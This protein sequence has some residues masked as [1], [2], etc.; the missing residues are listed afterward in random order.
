ME[1]PVLIIQFN[2]QKSTTGL[3]ACLQH[4][5]KTLPDPS[6]ATATNRTRSFSQLSSRIKN[7]INQRMRSTW[8]QACPSVS[9]AS[10]FLSSSFPQETKAESLHLTQTSIMDFF[11]PPGDKRSTSQ[12]VPVSRT[13]STS[14]NS[15]SS[16]SSSALSQAPGKHFVACLQEPPVRNDKVVGLP[17]GLQIFSTKGDSRVRAAIVASHGLPLWQVPEFSTPDL[18]VVLW[19]N[20]KTDIYIVS[21]Y[22]DIEHRDVVPQELRRLSRKCLRDKNP[23]LI[24]LDS[25]A[26]SSLWGMENN[27]RGDRIEE[28]LFSSSLK[29]INTGDK[30][31]F[32]NRRSQ[33]VIDIT[34]ASQGLANRLEHWKV[35]DEH[36][37]SDHK[38]IQMYL[39]TKVPP[40]HKVFQWSK[41]DWTAFF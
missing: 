4:V 19:K 3:T 24:C 11:S 26:H 16:Q 40:K 41:C 29:V 32:F 17:S 9:E 18:Q 23:I 6:A 37:C 33:T 5:R 22:L 25:N 1:Y 39:N 30:H 28:W 34:I 36:M 7:R 14:V 38:L 15:Q 31:T 10:D 12:P 13:R 27:S 21:G 8:R 35:V 2:A 20:D